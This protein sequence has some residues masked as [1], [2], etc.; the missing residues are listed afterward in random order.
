[1]WSEAFEVPRARRG[2]P[3]RPRFIHRSGLKT[4]PLGRGP[5]GAAGLT[6]IETEPPRCWLLVR[7]PGST[8]TR[9]R[10]VINQ[11]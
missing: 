8:S 4:L 9:S 11:G 7:C 10:A 3:H 1:M 6:S 2:A 5:L